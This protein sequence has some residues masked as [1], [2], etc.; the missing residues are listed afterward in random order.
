MHAMGLRYGTLLVALLGST[1]YACHRRPPQAPSTELTLDQAAQHLVADIAHQLGFFLGKKTYVIDPMIDSRTGQQTEGSLQA[2]KAF[3]AAMLAK[4]PSMTRIP[5]DSQGVQKSKLTISGV[6]SPQAEKGHYT[7]SVS[8]SDRSSGLVVAQAAVPLNEPTLSDTPTAF[9]RD[10]PSTVRDRSVE[11][12]VKTAQTPRGQAA[13]TLYVQQIPTAAVIATALEAYNAGQWEQALAGYEEAAARPDGQQLR[14]FNGIYLCN[15]ELGRLAEAEAA[16]SKIVA[17]GLATNNLAVKILFKPGSTEFWPDPAVSGLY[18]MWIRQ[19]AASMGNTEGCLKIVGHTSA[20]GT[21]AFNARLSL[22]RAK[23][24]R[25]ALTKH[26]PEVGKRL[27]VE[28]VGSSDNIVGTG[29]DDASD[30]LDRRV[31]FKMVNCEG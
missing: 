13:D 28:G 25:T 16:F 8:L 27:Q 22:D 10:T 6:L 9:Y 20:T 3:D 1:F 17:L 21:E 11:G 4:V 30:A 18:S 23:A 31:E 14:T 26:V 24:I 2:E 29:T 7:W 19:V 5:F 12:Y 15:V